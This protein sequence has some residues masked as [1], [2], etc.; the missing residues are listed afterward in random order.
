MALAKTGGY[1]PLLHC[2]SSSNRSSVPGYN[3]HNH[4]SVHPSE[5]KDGEIHAPRPRVALCDSD[6]S[7]ELSRDV[8][9]L[10]NVCVGLCNCNQQLRVAIEFLP[11]PID[12]SMKSPIGLNLPAREFEVA[13]LVQEGLR[14]KQIAGKMSISENTVKVYLARVFRRTG[15]LSR[16]GLVADAIWNT[17]SSASE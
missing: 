6:R 15:H 16:Y 13:R 1:A 5:Q 3:T 12:H 4:R 17:S 14:N 2:W 11:T 10:S 7:A 9:G 8:A